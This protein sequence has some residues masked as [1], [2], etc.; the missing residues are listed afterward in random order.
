MI[1]ELWR[2]AI[3]KL[4]GDF[5]QVDENAAV[6][7]LRYPGMPDASVEIDIPIFKAI[8]D[9][10]R[11]EQLDIWR[12]ARMTPD[13]GAAHAGYRVFARSDG[14]RYLVKDGEWHVIGGD[15]LDSLQRQWPRAYCEIDALGI[16]HTWLHPMVSEEE[17]S[18]VT[19][20]AGALA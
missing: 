15:Q 7:K 19:G 17:R 5:V 9:A 20:V 13:E 1:D 12:D 14:A 18:H 16:V 11:A 6:I 8:V 4:K 10:T 2:R 3:R